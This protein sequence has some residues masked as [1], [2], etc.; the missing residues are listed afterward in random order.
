MQPIFSVNR[1]QVLLI[2]A[3]ICA[4]QTSDRWDKQALFSAWVSC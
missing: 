4:I 3:H 1:S 2:S